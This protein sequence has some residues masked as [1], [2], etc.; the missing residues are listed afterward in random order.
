M[1]NAT[2]FMLEIQTIRTGI[3]AGSTA[4]SIIYV[5]YNQNNKIHVT[6]NIIYVVFN[7]IHVKTTKCIL[8]WLG[9]YELLLMTLTWA[10]WTSWPCIVRI[11]DNWEVELMTFIFGMVGGARNKPYTA[12]LPNRTCTQSKCPRLVRRLECATG[13][14]GARKQTRN[15]HI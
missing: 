3:G 4:F 2:C 1:L 9:A 14:F 11:D 10:T 15:C 6:L 8:R 13:Q 7:I 5:G 12:Y